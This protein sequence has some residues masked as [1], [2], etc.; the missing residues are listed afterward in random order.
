MGQPAQI[1]LHQG[2]WW[3][4]EE[5]GRDNFER[6]IVQ[7]VNQTEADMLSD[8]SGRPAE[9]II[10]AGVTPIPLSVMCAYK[11]CGHDFDVATYDDEDESEEDFDDDLLEGMFEDEEKE[12]DEG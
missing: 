12:E 10:K 4:C 6:A 9:D 3:T 7:E 8:M 2:W 11:D 5:C 1:R